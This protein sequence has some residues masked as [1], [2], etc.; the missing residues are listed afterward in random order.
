M[1]DSPGGVDGAINGK[2]VFGA[3]LKVLRAMS[4]SGVDRAGALF[5]RHV[6]GENTER[7][8]IE[9]RVAE[10]R[11]FEFRAIETGDDLGIAPPEFFG[12]GLEQ[13]QGD[14]VDTASDFDGYVFE[15]RVESDGNVGRDG[16]GRSGPDQAVDFA[17]GERGV[18]QRGVRG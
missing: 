12:H 13:F 18:D 5:E 3:D 6:L 11:S 9:K 7:I 4:G 2:P 15:F 8:A 16:P 17:A 14:Y 10:D 1:E